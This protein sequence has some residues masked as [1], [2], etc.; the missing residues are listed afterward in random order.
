MNAKTG[1]RKSHVESK[2][3]N[4]HFDLYEIEA[5]LKSIPVKFVVVEAQNRDTYRQSA[6]VPAS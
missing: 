4:P 5:S 6:I 3:E 2:V 1:S